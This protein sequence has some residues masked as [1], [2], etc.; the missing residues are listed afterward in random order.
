[1][2]LLAIYDLC[3]VL[4]PCGPLKCLID[5]SQE[6]DDPIPALLYEAKT[7]VPNP[8]RNAAPT[9]QDVPLV[10]RGPTAQERKEAE[11]AEHLRVEVAA[12]R[13][14]VAEM[15][16]SEK[17]EAQTPPPSTP[18]WHDE[19]IERR[20]NGK[21][22]SS[23]RNTPPQTPSASNKNAVVAPSSSSVAVPASGAAAAAS[24]D[25]YYY[26][27]EEPEDKSVKLGLG[28]F[29]MYSLLVGRAA[30]FG[31][32]T[33]TACFVAILAGL[34]LTLVCLAVL[35]KAL[36]AL[37]FSIFFAMFFYFTTRGIVWPFIEE[38]ISYPMT[39]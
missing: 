1:M 34:G 31:M 21:Q 24:G 11:E 28:D 6:R 36:P 20:S 37:P 17:D 18:D 25:E 14:Q 12:L 33:F 39:I 4:T 13:A 5:L 29:V 38:F 8:R 10:Q 19:D 2:F 7:V 3:A 30:S 27:E 15:K 16:E 9:S 23:A 22:T 32:A 26:D 35:R